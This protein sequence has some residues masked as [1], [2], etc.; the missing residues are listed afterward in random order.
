MSP[1]QFSPRAQ[2]LADALG[3][4]DSSARLSAAMAAGSPLEAS[5]VKVVIMR[6]GIEPD[7]FVRDMLT[8]ALVQLPA[9]LTLPRL[10]PELES[11]NPQARSQALHSLS[12]I[13]EPSTWPWT[14]QDMLRDPLGTH[15]APWRTRPAPA[16][17]A[18]AG[19]DRTGPAPRHPGPG[20][21]GRVRRPCGRRPGLGA[22]APRPGRDRAA[23]RGRARG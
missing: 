16:G 23:V 5:L 3:A 22:G 10:K 15:P 21:R 17:R 18:G 4:G 8:W 1:R 13:A 2:S 6:C 9:E 19:P 14:T 20:A 12:K 7:F 11:R